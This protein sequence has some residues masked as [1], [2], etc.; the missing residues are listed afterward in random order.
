M[1]M[2]HVEAPSLQEPRDPG[3]QLGV[4]Q[5]QGVGPVRVGVETRH[6]LRR[7]TQPVD[8]H[9][10]VECRRVVVGGGDGGHLHLVT[11]GDEDVGEVSHVTLLAPHDRRVELR[12]HQDAHRKSHTTPG[13]RGRPGTTGA[14]RAA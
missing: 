2:G 3:P 10:P 11:P 9:R 8:G 6:A 13:R 4:G 12:E 14:Y 7:R 1:G 5:R